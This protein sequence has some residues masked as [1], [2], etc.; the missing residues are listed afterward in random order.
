MV[1]VREMGLVGVGL[2]CGDLG[3]VLVGLVLVGVG[4]SGLLC[5]WFMV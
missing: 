1:I 4:D 5:C 3:L 2:G